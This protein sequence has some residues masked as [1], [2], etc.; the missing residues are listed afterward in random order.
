MIGILFYILQI[1]QSKMF[2]IQYKETSMYIQ[3]INGLEIELIFG[4]QGKISQL[5]QIEP[6]K[7]TQNC[8]SCTRSQ[9]YLS[10]TELDYTNIK[11]F[12]LDS[13]QMVIQP[14]IYFNDYNNN[15]TS[16]QINLMKLGNYL[17]SFVDDGFQLC[18]SLNDKIIETPFQAERKDF[19]PQQIL[20]TSILNIRNTIF[21]QINFLKFGD[22]LIDISNFTVYVQNSKM[23]DD[24]IDNSTLFIE[25]SF[26][27]NWILNQ[28]QPEFQKIGFNLFV[29]NTFQ[30]YTCEKQEKEH[31][32]KPDFLFFNEENKQN[33]II[34]SADQYLNSIFLE[35]KHLL[36]ISNSSIEYIIF[37][38]QSFI[39]NK[40]M[41]FNFKENFV[42]ISNYKE[43]R[44]FN[45]QVS[46]YY[47]YE[48]QVLWI[49]VP[50]I[51]LL[52]FF[53]I[54]FQ[55]NPYQSQDIL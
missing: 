40:K 2:E 12:D 16:S 9:C 10:N 47:L 55:I 52:S 49:S 25:F 27:P 41:Y 28:L 45:Y 29:R 54:Y 14:L 38:S 34:Y 24:C 33:P 21:F 1:V 8:Q 48:V 46:S 15:Q 39:E 36:K 26:F 5:S 17:N 11:M 50:S 19:D 37:L 53:L 31:E 13:Q 44:C 43:E 42:A 51:I 3:T 32:N 4:N 30:F 18:F 6:S 23:R 20:V 35:E 22:T 7:C